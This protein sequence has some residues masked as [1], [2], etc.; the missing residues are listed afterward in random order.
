MIAI[1]T[2]A[3][4]A[5]AL[6]EPEADDFSRLIGSEGGLAGTPT[7]FEARLALA[8]KMPRSHALQF[9][10]DFVARPSVHPVDFSFEMYGAAIDAFDRFGRG[11]HPARLNFGD[12]MAYAVARVHDAPLLYK[13]SDF[14]KT[15]VKSAFA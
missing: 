13:G 1:D 12:C 11:H 14:E 9:L 5:L 10:S 4:M 15:D 6:L 7:L 8:T 2:S 3:I